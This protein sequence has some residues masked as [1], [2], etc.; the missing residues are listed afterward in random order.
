MA[1]QTL[2]ANWFSAFASCMKSCFNRMWN[3]SFDSC[4]PGLFLIS[5]MGVNQLASL[6]A[7]QKEMGIQWDAYGK[8]WGYLG[9]LLSLLIDPEIRRAVGGDEGLRTS[10]RSAFQNT[11]QE[12]D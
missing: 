9:R 4:R 7:G 10:K 11:A 12:K 8:K 5:Q 6:L 2:P 1:D 3:L